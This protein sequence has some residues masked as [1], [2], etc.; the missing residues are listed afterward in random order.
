MPIVS[1]QTRYYSL[2]K[3]KKEGKKKEKEGKRKMTKNFDVRQKLNCINV[4]SSQVSTRWWIRAFKETVAACLWTSWIKRG[5]EQRGRERK[6][7]IA[8]TN[9]EIN[10]AGLSRMH[11]AVDRFSINLKKNFLF[12]RNKK[13]RKKEWKN[14]KEF[15][16][17][18]LSGIS[19]EV[20]RWKCCNENI[21]REVPTSIF[22][23]LVF[24]DL[25]ESCP[26]A[27]FYFKF[28]LNLIRGSYLSFVASI[29][30]QSKV[31]CNA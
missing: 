16:F 1:L 2:E 30:M 8:S 7:S 5:R 22:A 10:N 19:E 31:A 20:G 3:G 18:V 13:K 15:T 27:A 12:C 28:T 4:T 21:R 9:R 29:T 26:N 14:K 11:R 23:P 17:P 25:A 6:I 24:I